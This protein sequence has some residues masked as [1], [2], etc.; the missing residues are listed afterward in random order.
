MRLLDGKVAIV[1]GAGRGLGREEALA[2]AAAGAKVIVNDIGT[3]VSGDGADQSPAAEVVAEITQAGGTA[4]TNG[5]NVA[6][7]QG[8]KRT[9]DQ[10]YDTW[11]RLDIVVNN[12]GVLRDRMSFNMSEEEFDLVMQVH[13]KGHFAMSRHAAQRWRELAKSTGTTYGRIVNTSS[14]AGLLGSAGNSNYGMAKAAIAAL[15]ISLAREM[16]KYGVTANFIAPR[17]RT[18]MTDTMP[19]AS[20]FAKPESGFDAFHPAWPA[21]LVVFLASEQAGDLN[22][23]GFIVWGGEVML[24]GGWHIL[25]QIS[26]PNAA[27][28]AEDLVARKD[29]LFGKHPKQPGYM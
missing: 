20:M 3:S 16:G 10:A 5:E 12:A 4:A 15:T 14:E 9:I 22:G 28:T 2:L 6:D 24:V 11:G 19:N 23:Q 26:K 29:E 25:N 7:W 27:F 21:Q 13:C 18:R 8:A 1:T 17:A